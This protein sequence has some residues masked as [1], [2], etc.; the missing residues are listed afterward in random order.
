MDQSIGVIAIQSQ[1]GKWGHQ[2]AP[3]DRQITGMSGLEDG[4][5]LKATG[6]GVAVFTKVNKRGYDDN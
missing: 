4:R 5:Y 2:S 6:P 3:Q 1:K